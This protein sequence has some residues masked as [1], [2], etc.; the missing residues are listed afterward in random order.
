[1]S[2]SSHIEH[3]KT[4][5]EY[6]RKRIAF[7]SSFGVTAIIAMFWVSSFTAFGTR[8]SATVSQVVNNASTP[9]QSLVASVG[10]LFIDFKNM[11]FK[12]K[13]MQYGEVEVRPGK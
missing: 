2:L 12:P 4:K 13:I 8:P 7:W 3:L 10:D 11:F 6:I 5:P 9:A 1:M